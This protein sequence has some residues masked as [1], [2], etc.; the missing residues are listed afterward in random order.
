MKGDAGDA[1]AIA[2]IVEN[3]YGWNV[4]KPRAIDGEM[5]DEIYDV[6]VKDSYGLGVREFFEDKNPAALQEM[7]AVMMESARKG[8]WNASDAQLSDIAGLHTYL[9]DKYRPACTGTVC[10]NAPLRDFIA[11]RADAVSAEKYLSGIRQAREASA[12]GGKGVVMQREDID[13]LSRRHANVLNN[14]IIAAV[15]VAVVA[16]LV[17]FVRKRRRQ[18]ADDAGNGE[19]EAL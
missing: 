15:S 14:T 6:Y 5:W 18:A 17:I 13:S 16:F 3:T 9:I 7:T 12:A 1:G 2:E 11:S 10:D 19:G 4:M 8:L